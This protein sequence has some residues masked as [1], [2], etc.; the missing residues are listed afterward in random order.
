[1]F[2]L[3]SGQKIA[4]SYV[5]RGNNLKNKNARVM[6]LVHDTS[7]EYALQIYEVSLKYL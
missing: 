4:I 6:V 3:Q 7:S 1:M 2:N 5:T